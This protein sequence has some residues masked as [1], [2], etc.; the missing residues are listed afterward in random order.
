VNS[1][2]ELIV[3]FLNSSVAAVYDRRV[4]GI[5]AVIDRRYSY[6]E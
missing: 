6:G 4:L 2:A 3:D 5:S 1:R